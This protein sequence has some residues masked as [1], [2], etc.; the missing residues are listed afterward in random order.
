MPLPAAIAV[1]VQRVRDMHVCPD[2]AHLFIDVL[3]KVGYVEDATPIV[4]ARIKQIFS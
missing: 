1:A 3:A 2:S 4:K